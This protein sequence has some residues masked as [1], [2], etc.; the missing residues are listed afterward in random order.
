MVFKHFIMVLELEY[1]LITFIDH[2]MYET[3]I[4]QKY[5]T[6]ASGKTIIRRPNQAELKNIAART[7][8]Q[9]FHLNNVQAT[10]GNVS[11]ALSGMEKKLIEAGG[12][13][14]YLSFAPLFIAIA[15]LLL[16]MEVFIPEIKRKQL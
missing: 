12:E 5:Q 13:R 14:E 11:A 1:A 9:Y 10:A 8:G 3:H 4:F 2:L 15:L 7:G 6:V 16:V